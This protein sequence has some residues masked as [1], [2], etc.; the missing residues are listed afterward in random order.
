[1][2]YVEKFKRHNIIH[3]S[4]NS[5]CSFLDEINGDYKTW[6]SNE[7]LQK[8]LREFQMDYYQID[9]DWKKNWL[10]VLFSL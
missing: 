6:W 2:N 10:N 9:I 4:T 7:D 3:N 1:M 5:I 8:I